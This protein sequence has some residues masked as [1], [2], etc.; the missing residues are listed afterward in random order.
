MLNLWNNI[1]LLSWTGSTASR[2]LREGGVS[3]LILLGNP[4]IKHYVLRWNTR[5][6]VE[7]LNFSVMQ[8]SRSC[9]EK[10]SHTGLVIA[11]CPGRY[12]HCFLH[13]IRGSSVSALITLCVST[14]P[15]LQS[16]T[17]GLPMWL[18][19]PHSYMPVG[20]LWRSVIQLKKIQSLRN[21]L[22]SHISA[23]GLTSFSEKT[24]DKLCFVWSLKMGIELYHQL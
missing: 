16:C 15:H 10:G 23:N 9:Y 13:T 21:V 7:P 24:V 5:K 12:L 3:L 19:E 18:T 6:E 11:P 14:G 2:S 20:E 8:N 22:C 4:G 17:P 1:S